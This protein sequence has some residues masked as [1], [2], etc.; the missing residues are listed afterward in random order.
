MVSSNPPTRALHV[1]VFNE[2]PL[3]FCVG[4]QARAQLLVKE[5]EGS[6]DVDKDLGV[7]T[8]FRVSQFNPVIPHQLCLRVMAAPTQEDGEFI[9]TSPARYVVFVD[10]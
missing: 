7:G 1:E 8:V 5:S 9:V 3:L 4:Q 6:Q 2:C 10:D